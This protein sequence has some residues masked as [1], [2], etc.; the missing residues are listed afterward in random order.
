MFSFFSET[1][2]KR[3]KNSVQCLNFI[4]YLSFTDLLV[5]VCVLVLVPLDV[6][7]PLLPGVV[8][9]LLGGHRVEEPVQATAADLD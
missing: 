8:E 1:T 5:V 3:K 4:R 2:K 9:E 7:R 6:E